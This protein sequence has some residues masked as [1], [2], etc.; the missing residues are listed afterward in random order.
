MQKLLA[1]LTK[2]KEEYEFS[3]PRLLLLLLLL[4]TALA[5][6]GD[7]VTHGI[8]CEDK[9]DMILNGIITMTKVEKPA[10]LGRWIQV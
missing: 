6:S 7:V 8:K 5:S 9:F 3:I 1:F 4:E 10:P 2:M